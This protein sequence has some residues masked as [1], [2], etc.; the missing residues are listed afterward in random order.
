MG[1]K[2]RIPKVASVEAAVRVFYENTELTNANI[3][4]LFGSISPKRI[5]KLKEIARKKSEEKETPVWSA[6]RVNT[7][8][9]FEAWGLDIKKLEARYTRLRKM[10]L[11]KKEESA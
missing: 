9:A 5:C 3:V 8:D 1:E 7:E 6:V 11:D 10:G 2:V 4:E